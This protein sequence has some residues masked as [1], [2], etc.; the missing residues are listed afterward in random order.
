MPVGNG[1]D[2]PLAFGAASPQ[3]RH[4][5]VEASFIYEDKVAYLFGMRGQPVLTFAP[6]RPG[7]LNI[8]AFLLTGVCRFF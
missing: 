3:A 1:G 5:G 8:R 7:R 2:H 4:L 6:Y